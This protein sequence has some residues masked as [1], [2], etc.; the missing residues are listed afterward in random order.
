[1]EV[2]FV[3]GSYGWGGIGLIRYDGGRRNPIGAACCIG[4]GS[5]AWNVPS[6]SSSGGGGE[7]HENEQLQA[8]C[9]RAIRGFLN[10][11]ALRTVRYYMKEFHDGSTL[12]WLK[13]FEEGHE[14]DEA[15]EDVSSYL[16]SMMLS[17]TEESTVI[18]RHPKGYFKREFK[19]KIEPTR[20]A[21]RIM[22][23]KESVARELL[24][25]LRLIEAENLELKRQHLESRVSAPD[26][27]RRKRSRIFDCDSLDNSDTPL[28]APTYDLLKK[29]LTDMAAQRTLIRYRD[30]S[31]HDYM[32]LL[33][34]L[35]GHPAT[36]GDVFLAD[37]LRQPVTK[38]IN[39]DHVI[40][41]SRIAS[42]IMK[43]R[44]L[45]AKEWEDDLTCT[46]SENMALKRDVLELSLNSELNVPPER[47][48]E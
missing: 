22:E 35:R 33:H 42:R 38:R 36:N 3:C 18:F 19:V 23:A 32:W 29:L 16:K 39:P 17:P 20:I 2:G 44:I 30:T 13:R 8:G 5:G 34:F 28:R 12:D 45:I 46:A 41:P 4:G 14:M 40:D 27:A 24:E 37:L 1:M 26:L 48:L 11:R 25:D 43:Y 7:Y 15:M 21:T 9:H 31:N 6:S 10:R 47:R